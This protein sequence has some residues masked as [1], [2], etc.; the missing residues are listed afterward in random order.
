MTQNGRVEPKKDVR[1]VAELLP[2][3]EL[4]DGK[5]R[6]HPQWQ[7]MTVTSI[8]INQLLHMTSYCA[9]QN[10]SHVL[11]KTAQS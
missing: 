5:F 11:H 10:S 9:N 7:G 6:Q 2:F 1:L 3:T 4:R 8:A